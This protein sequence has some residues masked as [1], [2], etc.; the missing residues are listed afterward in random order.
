V[1]KKLT[2]IEFEVKSKASDFRTFLSISLN[3][4]VLS[5]INKLAKQ[6][7]V[8]I[9][10]GVIRDFFMNQ[11][12]LRDLDIMI[13]GSNE[14][15]Q[16]LSTYSYRQNSYGGYKLN[17][18]DTNVDLWFIQNTWAVKHRR[19]TPN[20][21]EA[22][23]PNTSF[24]NFSS[25]V[26]DWEESKFIVGQPFL[27]FLSNKRINI[28]FKHNANVP[29]CVVNSL[30]YSRKLNLQ[31]GKKLIKYLKLNFNR[32]TNYDN[33]Q[34]KHFGQVLFSNEELKKWVRSLD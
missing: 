29:L 13:D 8:Y 20:N 2:D 31:I 14:I 21:I 9:F 10:S 18:G 33:V 25:I 32:K 4:D 34:I 3:V 11:G 6:S 17:I 16:I 26:Y 28:V 24:F 7:R 12:D 5:F 22:F 1:A 19:I 15:E 30:Y 23:I 27:S